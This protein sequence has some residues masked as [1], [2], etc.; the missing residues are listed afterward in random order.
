MFENTD[1][2]FK[3][4]SYLLFLAI[5]LIGAGLLGCS[6]G[7]AQGGLIATPVPLLPN[8][9]KPVSK[10][11]A[12]GGGHIVFISNR[13]SQSEIYVMNADGTNSHRLTHGDGE[14]AWPSFSPDAKSILYQATVNGHA[15][16]F[17]MDSDGQTPRNLTPSQSSEE[18]P[19][20]S[21][22]GKHIAFTSDRDGHV[23][24]YVMNADGTGVTHLT[25][26]P[27]NNW[28]PVWAPDGSAIAFISDRDGTNGNIFTMDPSGN[29]LKQVTT[30][31]NLVAKP[32]WA[33][34][35]RHLAAF[36][37]GGV[38]SF[39][40]DGDAPAPIIGNAEDPAWSQD[41]KLIAFASRRDGGILQIYVTHPDG[42][43]VQRITNS[44]GDD[45]EPAWGQ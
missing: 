40:S 5:I 45:S 38:F 2:Q 7:L 43:S 29:R 13:E 33:P 15:Q 37:Q 22:D 44:A 4:P 32:T 42:S 18:F 16:I 19:S 12:S 30:Q 6:Q 8:L 31:D 9:S 36:S 1:P 34:D 41:G 35:S 23:G 10:A 39:T 21:P 25:D 28:F 3:P 27:S 20:W 26:H 17:V 11:I 24:I 14:K